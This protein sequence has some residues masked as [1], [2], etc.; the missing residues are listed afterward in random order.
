MITLILGNGFDIDLGWKTSFKDFFNS[1]YKPEHE[2]I[3][4]SGLEEFIDSSNRDKNYEHWYNLEQQFLDFARKGTA[5][6]KDDNVEAIKHLTWLQ[7][8]G[9]NST[10]FN[11]IISKLTD[12]LAAESNKEINVNSC[13]INVLRSV[14]LYGDSKIYTFNYT[15]IKKT[16]EKAGIE[17]NIPVH[18]VHGS[19]KNNDIILGV[20]DEVDMELG[21][22]YLQKSRNPNFHKSNIEID[23]C[24][25]QEVVFFGF[26]FGRNDHQYLRS[27][28]EYVRKANIKIAIFTFN[29]SSAQNIWSEIKVIANNDLGGIKNK[30]E[31][32]H[33]CNG[34]DSIQDFLKRIKQS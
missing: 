17:C 19:L 32:K 1:L 7:Q 24:S 27:F 28:F 23:L 34:V 3:Y 6:A 33:T 4:I 5:D 12:Y 14:I 8:T 30:I 2:G 10:F 15:D 20:T 26:S 22:S 25:S 21:Y 9:N 13:A 11:Q 18:Y 16:S 31:V 29:A